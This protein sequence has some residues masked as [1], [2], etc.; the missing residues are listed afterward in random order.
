MTTAVIHI[1]DAPA[2]WEREPDYAYIGRPKGLLDGPFGNPFVLASEQDRDRL[3]HL[4]RNY[5]DRKIE[6]DEVFRRRIL[7]L[8]GKILVCYCKPKACHGDVIAEWLDANP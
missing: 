6:T 5:F 1:R 2:G 3:L 4:Y 8:R 7:G